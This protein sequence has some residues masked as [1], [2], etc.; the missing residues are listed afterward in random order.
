LNPNPVDSAHF[1]T[2]PKSEGFEDLFVRFKCEF[3]FSQIRCLVY[4]V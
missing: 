4:I 3:H 1:F 2:N